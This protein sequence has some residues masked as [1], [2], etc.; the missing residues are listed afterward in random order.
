MTFNSK[1][2]D[3]IE[4]VHEN[5]WWTFLVNTTLGLSV[6]VPSE[7]KEVERVAKLLSEYTRDKDKPAYPVYDEGRCVVGCLT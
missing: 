4:V 1:L 7:E 3:N 2:P 5:K 6:S